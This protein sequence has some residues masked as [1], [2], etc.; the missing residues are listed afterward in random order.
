MYF[1]TMTSRGQGKK[2]FRKKGDVN[3]PSDIDQVVKLTELQNNILKKI[4]KR[5]NEET[6]K[7]NNKTK[8]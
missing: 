4:I 3:D 5:L 6:G 2:D 7:N 1:K 8:Q